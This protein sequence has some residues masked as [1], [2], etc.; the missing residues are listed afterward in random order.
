MYTDHTMIHVT[1]ETTANS[2]DSIRF[3]FVY[4]MQWLI[5]LNQS[6]L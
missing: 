2:F 3:E 4:V 5:G 1:A 6:N